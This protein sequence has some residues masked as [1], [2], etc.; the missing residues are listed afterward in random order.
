MHHPALYTGCS[1]TTAQCLK[2]YIFA[3]MSH[4]VT[5]F[6]PKC[7]EFNWKYEKGQSFN[8][9]FKRSSFRIWWL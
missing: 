6:S 7:S 2:H 5:Q 3:I 4:R 1:R 8:T 9:A